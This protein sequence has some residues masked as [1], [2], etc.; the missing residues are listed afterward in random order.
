MIDDP[1]WSSK[2]MCS[3]HRSSKIHNNNMIIKC[4]ELSRQFHNSKYLK[5]L[6]YYDFTFLT[7][8]LCNVAV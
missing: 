1:A 7:L 2:I 3:L 4:A 5:G 8:V 6:V